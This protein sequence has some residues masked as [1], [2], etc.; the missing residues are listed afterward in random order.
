MK[1]IVV[2][3]VLCALSTRLYAQPTADRLEEARGQLTSGRFAE[4]AQSYRAVIAADSV[5]AVAW[6]GLANALHRLERYPEALQA[7]DRAFAIRPADVAVRFNRGLTLSELGRFEEAVAELEATVRLRPDFAPG[8]TELG[9]ARA[10]RGRDAEA[11]SDWNRAIALDSN[12]IW[13][14]YYRGLS[15][16][17]TGDYRSAAADFDA[18]ADRETLLN[19]HLWRWV[20][21]RLDGRPSTPLTTREQGWPAPIASY[22]RG[23]IS[24]SA[25][26]AAAR[27]D[28]MVLDDRRLGGAYFFIGVRQLVSGDTTGARRALTS[29]IEQNAPRHA[30]LV[31]AGSLLA[32]LQGVTRSPVFSTQRFAFFSDF[33]TNLND[34]L[35]AAGV[36]G[37]GRRPAF[38]TGAETS[39]FESLPRSAREDWERAAAFYARRIS[40]AG[41]TSREQSAL[42]LQLAGVPDNPDS[43]TR[44]VLDSARAERSAAAFAY[45]Q[46]RWAARDSANR[47]FIALARSWLGTHE[48]V[49]ARRLEQ[50]YERAWTGLPILVD[51]TETVSW[52][53]ANSFILDDGGGHLLISTA[54][55][56][57]SA[58]EVV[59]HESSHLLMV[60]NSPVRRALEAAASA[61]SYRLPDDLW[62]VV[63]FY[64]TGEVVRQAIFS[65]SRGYVPMVNEIFGRGTWTEFRT[66]LESEWLPYVEGRRSL[67]DAATGLIRSLQRR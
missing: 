51:V 5:N 1:L 17:A 16:V 12:Y 44:Q 59:F 34:A 50:L 2:A 41:W 28:R 32:R 23:E 22:L 64:Q 47:Q 18:V 35:I 6:R 63:L 49:V 53:G 29:A 30:E 4:A 27:S 26:V 7:L 21:H 65:R 15:S 43:N 58:L 20:A 45:R 55:V 8:W 25:L 54:Y 40:P 33:E 3:G 60:R 10:L 19:A 14:R 46:C 52:S 61:A 24:D 56:G 62:H 67:T 39:C 11:R 38:N 9:A 57:P 66:A 13:S 31:A 36:T 42:R 48:E 37:N